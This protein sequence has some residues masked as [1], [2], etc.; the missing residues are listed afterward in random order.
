MNYWKVSG[1]RVSHDGV[2]T[3]DWIDDGGVEDVTLREHEGREG[4]LGEGEGRV[5]EGGREERE[6]EVGREGRKEGV[7]ESELGMEKGM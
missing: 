1:L 7:R 6:R 5:K 4:G 2:V 3:V